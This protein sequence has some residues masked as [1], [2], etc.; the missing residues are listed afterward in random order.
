MDFSSV[1]SI[2][3]PE[4]NV[5]SITYNNKIIWQCGVLL[6]A[7]DIGAK[8]YIPENSGYVAYIVVAHDYNAAGLTTLLRSNVTSGSQFAVSTPSS[9]YNNKYSGSSLETAMSNYFSLYLPSA[10]RSLF[11]SVS[12]PVRDNANASCDAVTVSARFFP[13]STMELTGDGSAKEG[14]YLP[15]FSSGGSIAAT[16]GSSYQSYWTRS[17]TGGMAGY[18]RAISTSGEVTS[19]SVTSSRYLRP[20]G[21]IASDVFVTK[22]SGKYYIH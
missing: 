7:L 10:T 3:I 8:V 16:D 21:C 12:V 9:V 15:Y 14:A 17:V 22:R 4:G 1:N 2:Q 18:A 19:A 6:G 20:A 5:T 11:K 13:L